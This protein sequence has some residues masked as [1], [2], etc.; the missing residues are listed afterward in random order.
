MYT[1]TL[2]HVDL[3]VK[4]FGTCFSMSLTKYVGESTIHSCL[5]LILQMVE[6]FLQLWPNFAYTI[7]IHF[8]GKEWCICAIEQDV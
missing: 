7:H 8:N 4:Q 1:Y 5:I 2:I 6:H 3:F